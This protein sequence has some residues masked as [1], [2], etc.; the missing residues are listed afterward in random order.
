M[1]QRSIDE[2]LGDMLEVTNELAEATDTDR[3]FELT[4][5][6][7]ELRREAAE[8]RGDPFEQLSDE[9]L[10]GRIRR[11]EQILDEAEEARMNPGAAGLGGGGMGGGGLDPLLTIEHN[12]RV[13]RQIGRA[14]IEQELRVLR[15]QQARRT[16]EPS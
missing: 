4:L 8:A 7:N 10:R 5:R 15:A 3:T 16:A 12:Q 14:E 9:A 2:I 6:R 1:V 13:D 11:C